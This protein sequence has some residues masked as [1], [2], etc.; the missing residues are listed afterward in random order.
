MIDIQNLKDERNIN[1]KKVGVKGL[2]YPIVV[3]D[4]VHGT[5]PVNATI[6]MYVSLLHNFKG[7]HMSRFVEVLND[8][9]EQV[10]IRTFHSILEKIRIKLRAESAHI[11]IEFPYFIEKAAPR[12]GVKSLMEYRCRFLGTSDGR[13]M[14]FVVGVAVPVTTVCPCSREISRVG[15]HNQRSIVTVR[16]R[17]HKFFWIEDVIRL[18][19]DSASGEVYSLLKRVDE[20]YVTEKGYENPM[21]VED[22]VRNVAERLSREPNFTWYRVEAENFESIH[23]H[24]AYACLE[25]E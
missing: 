10:N 22:V 17:F 21:F 2:K 5:Q 24:S 9:R 4:R 6:N 1:I 11:E 7:T 18:I 8:I 3:L 14:D 16:V 19:E 15:A 13:S 12:S 23:N 20:K 25:K